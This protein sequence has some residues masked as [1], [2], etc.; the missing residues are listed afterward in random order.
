MKIIYLK[1]LKHHIFPFFSCQKRNVNADFWKRKKYSLANIFSATSLVGFTFGHWDLIISGIKFLILLFST[2]YSSFLYM[3][4]KY[5]A[6][7]IDY[8]P[9]AI[10]FL[11]LN[12]IQWLLWEPK[13]SLPL[14]HWDTIIKSF[15][16]SEA[17]IHVK[18]LLITYIQL[19]LKPDF[20]HSEMAMR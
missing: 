3:L 19:S 9:Q 13:K 17:K 4:S 8:I 16:V 14:Q 18:L 6:F 10:H 2:C 11:I 12:S 1:A 15:W 20:V 5:C 7:L